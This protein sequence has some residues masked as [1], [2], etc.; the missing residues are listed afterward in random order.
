MATSNQQNRTIPKQ[1]IQK[2]HSA[3]PTKP[4]PLLPQSK[5]KHK[6][7]NTYHSPLRLK[8]SKTD[9]YNNPD[10]NV[11]EKDKRKSNIFFTFSKSAFNVNQNE[12]TW[13]HTE[14]QS[15]STHFSN[16]PQSTNISEA[17]TPSDD[18]V[19]SMG[20]IHNIISD[21]MA[22]TDQDNKKNKHKP[23]NTKISPK[24]INVYT[25]LNSF[26]LFEITENK[27][28]ENEPIE[29][30]P[31]TK[32]DSDLSYMSNNECDLLDIHKD[33]VTNSVTL[34][35]GHQPNQS[36]MQDLDLNMDDVVWDM[37][38]MAQSTRSL[39]NE[40]DLVVESPFQIFPTRSFNFST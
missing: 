25:N 18:T 10:Q 16:T 33:D 3:A 34:S 26:K 1:L 2:R 30:Y 8:E 24:P 40:C 19:H 21:N 17:I 23:I 7:T 39:T 38:N 4:L 35:S 37:K 22:Y 27:I 9:I 5:S 6:K 29:N 28:S 14:S 36:S 15:I 13:Q 31:D 11:V 12:E 20:D 32:S